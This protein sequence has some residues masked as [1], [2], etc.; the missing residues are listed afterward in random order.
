MQVILDEC[1][2]NRGS[3]ALFADLANYRTVDQLLQAHLDGTCGFPVHN[4][5]VS[6]GDG[7]GELIRDGQKTQDADDIMRKLKEIPENSRKILMG[8][9]TIKANASKSEMSIGWVY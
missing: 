7:G 1:Y 4:L 2:R 9:M 6:W 5:D 8:T 3:N